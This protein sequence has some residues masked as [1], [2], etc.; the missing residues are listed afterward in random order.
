M[1]NVGF[2]LLFMAFMQFAFAQPTIKLRTGNVTNYTPN[3]H[4]G[5]STGFNSCVYNQRYYVWLQF[6]EIPTAS[7][8]QVLQD[9]QIQLFNYLPEKTFIA[10]FP[11]QYNFSKLANYATIYGVIAPQPQY[12]LEPLLFDP[13]SIAWA[14]EQDSI[15]RV[16]ISFTPTI[17]RDELSNIL[18]EQ[19][20]PFIRLPNDDG[21]ELV[22][23]TSLSSL[24]K[25]AEHPL[26]Q[27]I[28]PIGA[29]PV[30]E[31]LQGTT[32]HRT[33]GLF[34]SDNWFGG[35]KLNGEGE[36]IAV[37]D[38]GFINEHI[39]F[40]GRIALNANNAAAANT[41]G[42]HC[43]GIILGAG[44]L[45]PNIRGQAPAAI[46]RAYDGYN[47]FNLY[48][49]IYTV[50]NV[51]ITSH[52]L[53]QTCNGG[54]NS[55]ARTNDLQ[56]RTYPSL[57]HVHSAGNSGDTDCGGLTAGFMTITGGYKA[58]KNVLT[59]A[60]VTKADFLSSSSSKGP[61]P[62]GRL[63]P[64]IAAV[65][66]S[67]SS[68]QPNNTF[69]SMTGTSMACPA[70]AGTLAL[71]N[72]AYKKQFSVEPNS[73]LI[74]AI[75][76]NTAD[77]LGHEG[78][79]F[80]FGFGRVNARRA[81]ECIESSRFLTGTATQGSTNTHTI[82]VPANVFKAKVMVYWVDA[83]ASAGASP[84]LVNDLNTW[85]IAPNQTTQHL[86]WQLY[87]G[88]TPT[89]ESCNTPAVKGTD[90]L[91]NV[92]QIEIDNPA[93]GNYTLHVAGSKVP[94]TT[95]TYYV[96]IEYLLSNQIVVTHPNGGESF[97][98]REV[99]RIRWDASE[100]LGNFDIHS[101]YDGGNTWTLV[102]SGISG[103]QRYFDWTLPSGT[104]SLGRIRVSRG[105]ASDISDTNFIALNTPNITS[106]VEACAGTSTVTWTPAQ[107]ATYYEV[108]RLG[109]KFMELVATTTNT[110]ININ[111]LGTDQNW[112]AVRASMGARRNSRR[113]LAVS[114]TNSSTATC[115]LPL[116]LLNF[117]ASKNGKNALLTWQTAEEQNIMRFVVE[118]STTAT[119][120]EIIEVGFLPAKNTNRT[121]TYTLT[122]EKII[123]NGVY[124]YRLKIIEFDKTIYSNIQ[125]LEWKSIRSNFMVYPNPVSKILQISTQEN[126]GLAHVELVNEI[127]VKVLSKNANLVVG[128][129]ESLNVANLA[130]GTYFLII[131]T[132]KNNQVITRETISIVR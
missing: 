71:L 2:I 18:H 79:D 56:I 21:P 12:K 26:V 49:S 78:P 54:Y 93:S 38:D 96:V 32:N 131:R 123:V 59:V 5:N 103:S 98:S 6:N 120:D 99:Q 132:L 104:T 95:Q 4:P 114:H 31:D 129:L 105:T 97:A 27:Y 108:F 63:K 127:G 25:I 53:G 115:S 75:M 61:L 16:Y 44:N 77:D 10:S 68:T 7:V 20:I 65:G 76:M 47:D 15:R 117:S 83:A 36:V 46:L 33:A 107:N 3:V 111:N 37:G 130:S 102:T 116:Q 11:V 45:N 55:N 39:D 126:V 42:D 69:A 74:K 106:I 62:D 30:K 19:A 109:D 29:P 118:R 91:N 125:S 58:G 88:A 13:S 60:N 101:S 70:V 86:P 72:Q 8:K 24:R 122:D 94:S 92:E 100:M 41:H 66:T 28:E 23:K 34:T 81:V 124:Y 112:I 128:K 43:S 119:F 67:V 50:D 48:P 85:M 87:A 17:S 40:K 64:D 52:S 57:M 121:T 35:R 84:S 82:Q 89:N 9:D 22:I 51:R 73:G 90:T 1:R 110:S 80:S 113:S 14:V